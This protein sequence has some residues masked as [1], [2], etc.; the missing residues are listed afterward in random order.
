MKKK[1][2]L[3]ILIILLITCIS[4]TVFADTITDS[5]RDINALDGNSQIILKGEIILETVQAIG[6]SVSLIMIVVIAIRFMLAS[7]E[8]KAELKQNLMP[9]V[10]GAV[11]IFAASSLLQ[12]PYYIGEAINKEGKEATVYY[13]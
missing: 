6:I 13:V 2:T 11:I 3:T 5:M 10:I 9:Y 12:I 7:T 1:L 4:T 8:G